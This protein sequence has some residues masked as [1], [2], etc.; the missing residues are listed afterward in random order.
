MKP[1]YVFRVIFL[2]VFASLAL[3]AQ[4]ARQVDI[5]LKNWSTPLYWQPNQTERANA[6]DTRGGKA[7]RL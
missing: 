5:P 4:V 6:G 3:T 2:L 7:S 1:N